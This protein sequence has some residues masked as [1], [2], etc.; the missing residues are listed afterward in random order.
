MFF[1]IR[2]GAGFHQQYQTMLL[3]NV[4][5]SLEKNM[6][7][8]YWHKQ[9]SFQIGGVV[10]RRELPEFYYEISDKFTISDTEQNSKQAQAS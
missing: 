5:H 8:Y 2:G 3:T 4:Q 1:D 6:N 7:R 9:G 10:L